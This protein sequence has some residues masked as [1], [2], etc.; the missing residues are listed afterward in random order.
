MEGEASQ[1]SC[2]EKGEI[3]PK[4]KYGLSGCGVL[5]Y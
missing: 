3:G 1:V 2:G 4:S 5:Q